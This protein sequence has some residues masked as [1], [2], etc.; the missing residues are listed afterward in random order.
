LKQNGKLTSPS[1]AAARVLAYLGRSN[2]GDEPVADV[3]DA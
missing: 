3:R 1:E 2:Y